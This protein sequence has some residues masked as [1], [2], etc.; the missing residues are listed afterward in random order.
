MRYRRCSRSTSPSGPPVQ[1]PRWRIP[2]DRDS[3]AS[4]PLNAED[5]QVRVA[6]S[7]RLVTHHTSISWAAIVMR[8]APQWIASH[9]VAIPTRL[10]NIPP[11]TAAIRSEITS[12]EAKNDT[13]T[14]DLDAF[15]HGGRPC[16]HRRRSPAACRRSLSREQMRLRVAPRGSL[17][18]AEIAALADAI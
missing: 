5:V 10:H 15:G 13:A 18:E 16:R 14:R 9:C 7:P 17:K 3:K 1:G 11:R 4:G 12:I 6:R 8:P 2:I